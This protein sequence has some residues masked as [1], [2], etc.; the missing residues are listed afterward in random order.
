M[1]KHVVRRSWLSKHIHLQILQGMAWTLWGG[2][3]ID[4]ALKGSKSCRNKR[5]PLKWIYPTAIISV[6]VRDEWRWNSLMKPL[7]NARRL[8]DKQC[9]KG[10]WVG[11][12]MIFFCFET[13][14]KTYIPLLVKSMIYIWV[15]CIVFVEL[16]KVSLGS[17]G[18]HCWSDLPIKIQSRGLKRPPTWPLVEHNIASFTWKWS[19]LA[20]AFVWGVG[21]TKA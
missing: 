16:E 3:C 10:N 21:H 8:L 19:A 9:P 14:L 2:K 18:R 7:R 1:R 15:C 17:I 13:S 20:K 6:I 4:N 12:I 11:Y 5:S